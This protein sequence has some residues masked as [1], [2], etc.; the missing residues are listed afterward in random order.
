MEYLV[1]CIVALIGSGLTLF[2]GFG[3]GTLLTPVFAIF[4]PLEMAIALTAIVHF[5]NNLFKLVLLGGNADK[6]IIFNFGIPAILFAFIGAY[7]LT[8]LSDMQP[9]FSYTVSGKVF[10]VMPVKLIIAGV[11]IFFSLFEIIPRLANLQFNEKYLILG[12]VLSGFFGGLSGNQGAL[13]SAFLIKA[14]L[15]KEAFIATGVVIA[16]MIDT[17]RLLVYGKDIF[18]RAEH[19]NYTLVAAATLSAFSG[20]YIGN[21]VLKKITIK[22]LQYIVAVL[23]CVFSV[24]LGAGV[25]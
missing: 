17:S 12:G 3:L 8:Q 9:L 14:R 24:L 7:L 1:I 20:A 19:F 16:C 10:S 18:G 15:G 4:F 22:T 13:R 25:V 23:L 11:L 6:K 2:S 5:L 21:K